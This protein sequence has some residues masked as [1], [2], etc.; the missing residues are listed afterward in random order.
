[1]T[2]LSAYEVRVA[3]SVAAWRELVTQASTWTVPE[4]FRPWAQGELARRRA[5]LEACEAEARAVARRRALA[6]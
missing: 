2:P 3:A 1:M 5:E 6:R 4:G